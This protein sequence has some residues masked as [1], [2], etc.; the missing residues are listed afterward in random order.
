[1]NLLQTTAAPSTYSAAL[2][3]GWI[4]QK[5]RSPINVGSRNITFEETVQ[6]NSK[7]NNTCDPSKLFWCEFPRFGDIGWNVC[8]LCNNETRLYFSSDT[9]SVKNH[10]QCLF[11]K[12]LTW[13]LKIIHWPCCEQVHLGTIFHLLNYIL[14]TLLTEKDENIDGVL[15]GWAIYLASLV[16]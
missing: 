6:P 8:F 7:M 4:V 11:P 16:S 10:Q 5:C 9:Q 15:H 1:M 12:I 14:S 3:V 13:L 2:S